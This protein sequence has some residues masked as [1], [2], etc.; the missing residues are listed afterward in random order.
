MKKYLIQLSVL[1][2]VGCKS[3]TPIDYGYCPHGYFARSQW[4]LVDSFHL[5]NET[6]DMLYLAK[7]GYVIR[8]DSVSVNYFKEVKRWSH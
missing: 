8:Q 3:D 1:I 2:F 6:Y 4:V 7:D 5:Y